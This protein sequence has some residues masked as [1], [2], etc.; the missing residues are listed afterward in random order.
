VILPRARTPARTPV[1]PST[2]SAPA[3][4]PTPS[5]PLVDGPR[6]A[7]LD[8]LR[9]IALI[10]MLVHHL[11]E[12]TTGDARAVLPGWPGFAVTDAAAVMFFVAAGGSMALFVGSRRRRGLSRRQIGAQV[13][14]RYGLL[15]PIGIALDWVLWRDPLMCGV[16][17]V[18]GVAVVLGAALA[19]AVPARALPA[20]AAAVV[21]GGVVSEWAVAGRAA[22]WANELIGGKFPL[23]SY[24][25]FVLVGV[26]AVRCGWWAD[27]R[28]M[29]AAAGAA[30]LAT[31]ALLA[32]GLAPD[33]YPGGVR[34]V[35]PGLA[36][37]IGVYALAQLRWG[38]V[39][40]G[41]DCVVR[42]AAAHTLGIFLA[43][44][45]LYA[46]LRRAGV[47]GDV[48][49]RVA[50]PAAVVGTV[51]LCLVAPRVPQPGWSLRTGRGGPRRDGARPQDLR[52]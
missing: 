36:I 43:H 18:L 37:T 7:A 3:A 16:L 27:R 33:R 29:A 14:R 1:L 25:G 12:W 5:A 46:L 40:A 17:E 4:P 51:A 48:P 26:A 34:F 41:L 8:R 44:Y 13:L 9:G 45:G 47:L 32:V 15:V 50:V 52:S 31:L 39:L 38:A 10:G 24:V 22:W 21:A 35:V 6:A 2:P 49:G 28:R 42:A 23:V 11:V 20:L 30:L 19:A